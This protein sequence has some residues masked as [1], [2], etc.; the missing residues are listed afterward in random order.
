MVPALL[1]ARAKVDLQTKDGVSPLHVACQQGPMEVVRALLST[2]AKINMQTKEDSSP[3]HAA[4][5]AGHTEM[6]FALSMQTEDGV[7]PLHTAC[8]NGH[9][10]VVRALLSAG[11]RADMCAI[12]GRTPL[13]VVPRALHVEM[14][15]LV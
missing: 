2:G 9:I 8:Y 7:S 15:R 10:G 14:E 11:A 12:D 4:C 3:L 13:D 5:Q 1:S 6:I